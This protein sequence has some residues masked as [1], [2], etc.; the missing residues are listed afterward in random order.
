[1]VLGSRRSIRLRTA[2]KR[3]PTVWLLPYVWSEEMRSAIA[4]PKIPDVKCRFKE[5]DISESRD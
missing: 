2:S 3:D 4:S 1:L 5:T